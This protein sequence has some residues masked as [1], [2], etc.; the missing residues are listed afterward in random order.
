MTEAKDGQLISVDLP[1]DMYEMLVRMAA[2]R[3]CSVEGIIRMLVSESVEG[4]NTDA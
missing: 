4:G 1:G 3:Q 2:E